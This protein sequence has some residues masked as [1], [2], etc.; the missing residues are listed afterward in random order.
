MLSVSRDHSWWKLDGFPM[1]FGTIALAHCAKIAGMI[2]Y[3]LIGS[4]NGVEDRKKM[5]Y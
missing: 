1:C 5:T 4:T 2:D 3:K